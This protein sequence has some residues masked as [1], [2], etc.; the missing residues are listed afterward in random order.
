MTPPKIQ[1]ITIDAMGTLILPAPSIGAVLAKGLSDEVPHG[2]DL[3]GA[4]SEAF[5][6]AHEGALT[7]RKTECITERGE[8]LFWGKV[9]HQVLQ[10]VFPHEKEPFFKKCTKKIWEAV[11]RPE[12]WDE[13]PGSR[14]PLE[15]LSRCG[16]KIYIFSNGDSRLPKILKGLGLTTLVEEVFVATDIGYRKPH[17]QAFLTVQ[18][19]IGLPPHALLHVS[20]ERELH[21]QGAL[22]AGWNAAFVGPVP[23]KNER[24]RH[25]QRLG[26]LVEWLMPAS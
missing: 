8:K 9:Y 1:A 25:L 14:P 11:G 15:L 3:E 16:Y 13:V 23:P 19:N 6:R 24:I 17:P 20:G 4:L 22:Q 2:V 21:A 5:R 10:A 7:S 18:E 26:D 12:N